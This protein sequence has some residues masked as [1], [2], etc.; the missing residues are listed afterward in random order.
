MESSHSYISSFLTLSYH[1]NDP[2]YHCFKSQVQLIATDTRRSTS[3]FLIKFRGSPILWASRRQ[4]AISRSSLES[5]YIALSQGCQNVLWILKLLKQIGYPT[6]TVPVYIDNQGAIE[7][8]KNGTHS[9]RTKDIDVAY[10][11]GRELLQAKVISLVWCPTDNM[12][13][14]ILTKA[15]GWEKFERFRS[16]AGVERKNSARPGERE[17]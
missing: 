16:A 2:H 1:N 15:L 6:S 10:K 9:E 7:S 3:G 8:T 17:C 11:Y 13:A 14:D 12:T 4:K 5:E